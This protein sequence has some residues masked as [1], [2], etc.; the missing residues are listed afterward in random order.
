MVSLGSLKVQCAWLAVCVLGLPGIYQSAR[1]AENTVQVALV[2]GNSSYRSIPLPNPV[3]D[4]RDMS[5]KLRKLGF[6][7]IERENLT[8]KQAGVTLREFRS[9]LKPGAVAL[10]FYAGHGLQLKGNNYLPMVD[11]EIAGE[12]DVPMQSINVNQVLDMMEEAKTRLNLVFLDACRN[13][14]FTRRF[15]SA[16]GGLAK[17]SAPSGTLISFATR[18]G[19]VASDGSGKNG[20]YTQHL[21]NHM[22]IP[23]QPIEQV[24]KRVVSGV[25]SE[26]RG[27]QEPWME[28]S[29]E[30]DFCFGGCSGA[31]TVP[32][33][34]VSEAASVEMTFWQSIQASQSASDY[35]AYLDQYP[36]GRFI[37][38]AKARLNNL[39]RLSSAAPPLTPNSPTQTNRPA[40]SPQPGAACASCSCS[41]LTAI[42]S[43]GVEPLTDAQTLFY[44]QNCR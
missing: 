15:R 44:R 34:A 5:A 29:I 27:E 20:L 22:D 7:V 21:L 35:Q 10:F 13:N 32:F 11:A 33:P 25:K 38:L 42:M 17:V 41:E 4:A 30:G 12:E 37:A 1:A 19:S 39:I 28:G 6:I 14:P 31:A 26:S 36:K 23:G 40:P 2:I 8:G 9:K 24:L 43:M 3:N 16:A 18:P